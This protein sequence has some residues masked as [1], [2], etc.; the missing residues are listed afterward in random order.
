M[1]GIGVRCMPDLNLQQSNNFILLTHIT[2]RAGN[3][4]V[5]RA[6]R[7]ASRDGNNVI[8]MI[9]CA[10][11]CKTIIAL[12]LLP[13][14]LLSHISG[15]MFTFCFSN[16]CAPIPSIRYTLFWMFLPIFSACLSIF[17]SVS[18]FMF[19]ALLS[20]LTK[21]R[22]LISAISLSILCSM[23]LTLNRTAILTLAAQAA[24][25]LRLPCKIVSCGRKKLFAI[26]ALFHFLYR[27]LWGM[28]ERVSLFM[29]LKAIICNCAIS[30]W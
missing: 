5:F 14:I 24:L 26:R 30:M 25:Y 20:M 19:T 28:L 27:W 4:D 15:S 29:A 13:I 1:S 17:F 3:H 23:L 7:A 16:A 21:L 11:Y 8:N 22:L 2:S 18:S 12:A 6:I 10:H 9:G